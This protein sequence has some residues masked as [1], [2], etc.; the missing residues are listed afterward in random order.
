MGRTV[1]VS[2]ETIRSLV[3]ANAALAAWYHELVRATREQ[4]AVVTPSEEIRNAFLRRLGEELP[5][6]S[7]VVKTITTCRVYVPSP[8]A[9]TPRASL[10]D[11]EAVV[12]VASAAEAP[13]GVDR[14]QLVNPRQVKY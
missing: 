3:E 12:P 5:E 13:V 11:V 2:E 14:P 6:V 7:A 8:L 10:A 4:N 9:F 1:I